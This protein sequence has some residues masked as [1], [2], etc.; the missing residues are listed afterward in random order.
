MHENKVEILPT[1]VEFLPQTQPQLSVFMQS[2]MQRDA[3]VIDNVTVFKGWG[4]CY[5]R[6][7][8]PE[9]S[10]CQYSAN[11][12]CAKMILVLL[13]LIYQRNF[14]GLLTAQ[15]F[16]ATVQW[17]QVQQKIWN[18]KLKTIKFHEWSCFSWRRRSRK[19]LK[20]ADDVRW[21]TVERGDVT[22]LLRERPPLTIY[23]WSWMTDDRGH[24]EM[25]IKLLP[26]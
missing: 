13:F 11:F 7:N 18:P 12:R 10:K 24:Y 3:T 23:T 19:G 22:L 15:S 4:C 26:W 14:E 5:F 25:F 8:L 21:F 20:E 2:I 1:F 16:N 9:E 6:L 17:Q